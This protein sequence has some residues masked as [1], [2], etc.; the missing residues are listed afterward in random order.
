[1]EARLNVECNTM[2]K[3]AVTASI[4]PGMGPSNQTLPL[5]KYSIFVGRPARKGGMRHKVSDMV[6]LDNMAEALD[7]RSEMFRMW[8]AKQ[9]SGFC[10]LGFR[11]RRRPGSP[12]DPAAA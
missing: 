5:E 8:Y 10:G 9:G 12:A 4:R 1:M 3:S 7:D 6:A 2:A 11:E